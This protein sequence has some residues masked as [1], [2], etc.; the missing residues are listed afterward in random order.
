MRIAVFGLGYVGVVTS[1]LLASHGHN[2]V[3]VDLNPVKVKAINAGESPI[4][5]KGLGELIAAAHENDQLRATMDPTDA[6]AD[7]EI[8]MICVGTPSRTNGS[9]DMDAVE[10]VVRETAGIFKSQAHRHTPP[11]IAIRSTVEP[12]TTHRMRQLVAHMGLE[13]GKDLYIVHNPEFLREGSAVRDFEMPPYTVIGAEDPLEAEPLST[14]YAHIDAPLFVT[15]LLTAEI[16]KLVNNTFHALKVSFANEVGSLAK[17][18]GIDGREVM[19]LVCRDTKLNISPAYLRP[20]FAF[21]GSCLPKDLRA[22]NA[23]AA[24]RELTLP[25]LANIETSNKLHIERAIRWL[26]SLGR[27]S[28]GFVG[29]A[30]KEE[31]DD[32]RESP[33]V[34]VAE[35]AVGRGYPIQIYDPWVRPDQLTGANREYIQQHLPHLYERLRTDLGDLVAHSQSL[36][37]GTSLLSPEEKQVLAAAKMPLLDLVGQD[38]QLAADSGVYEGICW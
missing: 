33:L 11:T 19:D 23:L 36:I 22:I 26:E 18:L 24:S 21:G 32:L 20:G 5:E 17:A 34:Q 29:L 15:P 28:V 31:T 2:I 9:L 6:L 10:L 14:L 38:G 30:F 13:P 12:G 35:W 8:A 16:L 3:G 1:G 37:V 4:A 25:L 7:A 27:H